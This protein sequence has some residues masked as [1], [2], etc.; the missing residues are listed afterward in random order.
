MAI[1]KQ[2]DPS[3]LEIEGTEAEEIEVEVINPEAMSL[4]VSL[5]VIGQ[6]PTLKV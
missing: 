2:M 1:E 5:A 6:E 3:D 4:T